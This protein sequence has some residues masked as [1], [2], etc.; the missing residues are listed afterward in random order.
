MI[1]VKTA[2]SPNR[3]PQT[4]PIRPPAAGV[5]SECLDHLVPEVSWL[6]RLVDTPKPSRIQLTVPQ[7]LDPSSCF[8]KSPLLVTGEET[9]CLNRT[10]EQSRFRIHRVTRAQ[11]LPSYLLENCNRDPCPKTYPLCTTL[12]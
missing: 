3:K 9:G 4:A 7:L 10:N 11:E 2:D 8:G 6:T 5:R 12:L 1:L